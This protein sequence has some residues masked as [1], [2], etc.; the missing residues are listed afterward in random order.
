MLETQIIVVDLDETKSAVESAVAVLKQGE[1]VALPTETVYG[2]AADAFNADAIAKV[3]EAK[4]RPSFNPLIVHIANRDQ[5]DQV[6]D[7]PTEI[8]MVVQELIANFWPGP[9]T[10]V[11]PKKAKLPNAITAGRST[12]AVRMSANPIMRKVSAS[13]KSPL[14]SPSANRSGR[15]SPTSAKAVFKELKGKIPLIIDGGACV[16][17]LEST[18]ISLQASVRRPIITILRPGP[19][20]K[21]QLQA[22]GKVIVAKKTATNAPMSPGQMESHYAPS[23]PLHLLNSPQ[24]FVAKK[25]VRYG[26]LSY[27][28]SLKDGYLDLWDWGKVVGLSPERGN[29]S[30]AAV[31]FFFALR[32]LDEAEEIDEIIAE[33]LS[34]VGLGLAMMNRLQ[35]ASN[36]A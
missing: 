33:P 17:G 25:G 23:K 8:E 27:R 28:E 30:E 34:P 15:I 24:D 35:R 19:V 5:L 26:L 12:V 21:E 36:L 10:I 29:L 4:C 31:R 13:L 3:F 18:I 14:A 1:V 11:L 2:L 7:I 32:E 22:H 16:H 9:L 6:A 20:T